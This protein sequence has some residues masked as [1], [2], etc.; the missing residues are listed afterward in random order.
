M[1]G[2]LS[3]VGGDAESVEEKDESKIRVDVGLVQ[4]EKTSFHE[5]YEPGICVPY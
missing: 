3:L 2:N 1:Q 5:L 4:F